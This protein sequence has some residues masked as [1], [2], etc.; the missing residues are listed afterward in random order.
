MVTFLFT[1]IEGSTKLWER[2]PQAMQEAIARHDELLK[3]A[4]EARAGYV[5]K[6]VGDAFC[7]AFPTAPDALEASVEAQ[8]L[9]KERWPETGHLRVRMALHTGQPRSARLAVEQ[10]DLER[11]TALLEEGVVLFREARHKQGLADAL[12]NLG[13][14]QNYGGELEQVEALCTRR[15]L[16]CSERRGIDGRRGGFEQPRPY[17]LLTG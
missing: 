11:G 14:A 3:G 15:A 16:S 8:R 12:D 13:I 2:N 4:I 10:G 6:T 7:A 17:R 5:F 1:D 9:L